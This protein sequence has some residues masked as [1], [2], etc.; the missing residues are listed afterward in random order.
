MRTAAAA[1]EQ[2]HA[3]SA[4]ATTAAG[5]SGAASTVAE[6]QPER[7]VNFV[8]RAQ[9]AQ[10]FCSYCGRSRIITEVAVPVQILLFQEAHFGCDPALTGS[11]ERVDDADQRILM[12]SLPAQSTSRRRTRTRGRRPP[13]HG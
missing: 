6:G 12:P 3:E 11:G 1:W 13:E 7:L 10:M 9:H 4:A 8:I 5:R 2:A